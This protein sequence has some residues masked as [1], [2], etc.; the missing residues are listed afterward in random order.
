M[1]GAI[2]LGSDVLPPPASFDARV[3]AVGMMVHLAFS[4]VLALIVGRFALSRGALIG[5]GFCS[6]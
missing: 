3:I 4:I 6:G 5:V 2:A 1:M